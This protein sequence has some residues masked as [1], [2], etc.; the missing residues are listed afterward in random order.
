MRLL[1]QNRGPI[2][3]AIYAALKMTLKSRAKR[4]VRVR[5][6]PA[7]GTASLLAASTSQA[8]SISPAD[9]LRGYGH[10]ERGVTG[11]DNEG[12]KIL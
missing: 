4:L 11:V 12:S 5:R 1:F 3:Q 7:V 2:L 6:E 10:P 8:S 9:L